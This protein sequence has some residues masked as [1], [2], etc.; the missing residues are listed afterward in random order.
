MM[1]FALLLALRL[2]TQLD[3]PF[4]KNG[5]DAE[6]L[7]PQQVFV[8]TAAISREARTALQSSRKF[9]SAPTYVF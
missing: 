8:A 7:L 2:S 6:S 9:C 3:F 5:Y 4:S 1:G